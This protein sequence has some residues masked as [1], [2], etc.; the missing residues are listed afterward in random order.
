M[1]EDFVRDF[2]N[3]ITKYIHELER[4]ISEDNILYS[5]NYINKIE[6]TVKTLRK[7]LKVAFRA[8]VKGQKLKEYMN[9]DEL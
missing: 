9:S 8:L 7:K 1:Q 3:D 5:E 2:F 6:T 4:Y